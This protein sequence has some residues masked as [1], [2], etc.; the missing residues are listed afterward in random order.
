[1]ADQKKTDEIKWIQHSIFNPA[2]LFFI[3]GIREFHFHRPDFKMD[4][5]I[6]TANKSTTTTTKKGKSNK[7]F[8]IISYLQLFRWICQLNRFHKYIHN[9]YIHIFFGSKIH[10]P[11]KPYYCMG[12][13]NIYWDGKKIRCRYEIE[14]NI[15][16][17]N[18]QNVQAKQAQ[19]TKSTNGTT[20]PMTTACRTEHGGIWEQFFNKT[21]LEFPICKVFDT[22]SICGILFSFMLHHH[23][24][25]SSYYIYIFQF[26]SLSFPR[27][28]Q[29][30][31][32][33]RVR[34]WKWRRKKLFYCFEKNDEHWKYSKGFHIPFRWRGKTI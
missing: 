32:R 26:C 34:R 23:Y 1:M 6:L 31:R 19:S 22:N 5:T 14:W 27:R 17:E 20:M 24:L 25:H 13:T 4:G 21:E 29:I 2:L 33:R 30:G 3:V 10:P 16:T 7:N 15:M 18:M 11:A 28:K 9:I 8:P 12:N